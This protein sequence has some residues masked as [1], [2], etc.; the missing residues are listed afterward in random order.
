MELQLNTSYLLD[1]I[2]KSVTKYDIS[3]I[4]YSILMSIYNRLCFEIP[5]KYVLS[6]NY[7]LFLPER[8]D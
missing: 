1:C 7:Q 8:Y 6:D 4:F 2:I 5:N 3:I